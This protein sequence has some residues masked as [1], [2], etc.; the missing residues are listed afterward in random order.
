MPLPSARLYVCAR[1]RIQVLICRRCD[2]GQI[3]CTGGCAQEARSRAQ[4]AAAH[5]Y[6]ASR[7]GRLR[8]AA[9]ARRYRARLRNKVTHQGSLVGGGDVVMARTMPAT[10]RSF[11]YLPFGHC[12]F[13]GGACALRVR[14]GFLRRATP[15][16]SSM[17]SAE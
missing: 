6:A 8:H 17:R 4:R 2:R 7:P 3:Y 11:A 10:T 14:Q 5:R 15:A 16:R 1:C 13:C 9:R 12:H